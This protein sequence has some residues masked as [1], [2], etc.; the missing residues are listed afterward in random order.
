[1]Y[2]PEYF[3]PVFDAAIPVRLAARS[4]ILPVPAGITIFFADYTDGAT[5]RVRGDRDETIIFNDISKDQAARLMAY[6][7]ETIPVPEKAG[8]AQIREVLR[9]AHE[10]LG[11]DDIFDG[12]RS[13]IPE[14]EVE[15]LH[16]AS[17]DC[18]IFIRHSSHERFA[19]AGLGSGSYAG[20]AST[21]Q[22]F[23][24]HVV[25]VGD[26]SHKWM[27]QTEV[28]LD[29]YRH[30]DGRR[31]RAEELAAFFMNEGAAPV[32]EVPE[33]W[34]QFLRGIYKKR[35]EAREA[36]AIRSGLPP[37]EVGAEFQTL[38]ND[39]GIKIAE[40]AP[41]AR[42][43]TA[44]HVLVAST[45]NPA[46]DINTDFAGEYAKFSVEALYDRIIAGTEPGFAP[47]SPATPNY[48]KGRKP[49]EP[50]SRP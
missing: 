25:V 23:T 19:L 34:Q 18:G 45:P 46:N 41:D 36:F 12:E 47:S 17:S 48:P 38:C 14:Y 43:C 11:I 27:V 2:T 35:D 4:F 33:E 15:A 31:I 32:R 13:K 42:R 16:P 22:Q 37:R 50:K 26:D 40:A 10:N 3:E 29:T 28:F 6:Y 8:E 20:P 24:G 9:Y 21:A 39:V 5:E 30:P 7:K 44:W 1:M 49:A